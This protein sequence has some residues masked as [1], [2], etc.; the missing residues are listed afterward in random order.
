[1]VFWRR[2]PLGRL[3]FDNRGGDLPVAQLQDA[4]AATLPQAVLDPVRRVDDDLFWTAFSERFAQWRRGEALVPPAS[5]AAQPLPDTVA[6]SVVVATRDRPGELAAC[7]DSLTQQ[8]TSRL[9]DIIVVDNHP[10]SGVTA[11]VVARF[12]SVRLLAEPRPGLSYARNRGILAARGAIVAT[13]D[14]D[15]VC[16][17]DWVERLVAPFARPE[18]M[19]VTGQVLPMTLDTLAQ[20]LFEMYGGLGRG[21]RPFEADGAW[22]RRCRLSVPT[23]ELGCTANAAFRASIFGDPRIGLMDEALGAGTPTGCSEDTLVFYRVLRAGGV[24]AYEPQAF[25]WHRHRETPDAFRRQLFSYSTGH[26]AYHLVT[27]LDHHDPRALARLALELP[28]IY[29]RR[30]LLRVARRSD[31]PLRFI[32]IELRGNL[33]APWALWQ[34]RRRVR[35]LGRSADARNTDAVHVE[36][37]GAE[38][39]A[40]ERLVATVAGPPRRGRR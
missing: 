29:A 1:V 40:A 22:F 10:A 36:G 4:I 17:P 7:L 30:V 27:L 21:Y 28:L 34:S 15:V 8:R 16:S 33:S 3:Q 39:A 24:V 14:D 12:P 11:P 18:V 20:Q 38:G 26:V 31:Y 2:R 35:A 23:W 6:V 25:V 32:A 19:V 13:T 9:V 37:A 5:A